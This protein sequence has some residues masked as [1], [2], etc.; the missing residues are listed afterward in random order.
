MTVH[1]DGDRRPGAL[2]VTETYYV[3][4]VHAPLA[5]QLP[6]VTVLDAAKDTRWFPDAA[7]ALAWA[8]TMT[9]AKAG[10]ANIAVTQMVWEDAA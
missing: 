3:G 4:K 1:V 7:L 5:T 6:G 2:V 10:T 8:R 9:R